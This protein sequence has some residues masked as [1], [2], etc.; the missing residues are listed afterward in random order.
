M[1]FKQTLLLIINELN[2]NQVD[3]GLIGGF[4]MGLFGSDRATTDLDFL[5]NFKDIDKIKHIFLDNGYELLFYSE[6]VLQFVSPIKDFGEIDILIAKRE[7]SLD[8]LKNTIKK[9]I[10]DNSVDIKIL[11]PEDIIGLKLQAIKNDKDRET[12]DR[13]DIKFL[14]KK[15]SLNNER[16]KKYANIL[17]MN[18]Y[19]EKIIGKGKQ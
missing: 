9:N 18:E 2:N 10:L 4:A 3:Y 5:I 1:D 19:L 13:N 8:M 15:N 16:I 6:N 12:I 14:I 17:N 11:M 7:I